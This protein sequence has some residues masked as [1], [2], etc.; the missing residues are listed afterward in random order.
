[1]WDQFVNYAKK[2]SVK[3]DTA[4]VK[5][6]E[7]L[8]KRLEAYLARFRWR[9]DGY[10]QVLNNEDAVVKKALDELKK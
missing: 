5:Q 10:F 4:S 2:D 8:Q 3:L 1:M 7:S 6:K 9:N